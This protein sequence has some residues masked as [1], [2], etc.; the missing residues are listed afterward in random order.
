VKAT[1]SISWCAAIA[2]PQLA[3]SPK[4]YSEFFFQPT[5]YKVPGMMLTTPGGK[6]A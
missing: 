2:L 6:P 4:K 3:P 1:L 5:R